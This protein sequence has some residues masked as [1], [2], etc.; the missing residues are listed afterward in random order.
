VSEILVK[1][2]T[3]EPAP[4]DFEATRLP[5]E[6]GPVL[7]RAT[8]KEPSARYPSGAAMI[9]ALRAPEPLAPPTV[10]SGTAHP[11]RPVRKLAAAAGVPSSSPPWP[12]S[13]ALSFPSARRRRVARGGGRRGLPRRLLGREPR[14]S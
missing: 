5:R 14:L 7:L 8:A 12:G 1:V 2:L 4:V 13:A 9:E 6:V 3:E 11:R 10:A